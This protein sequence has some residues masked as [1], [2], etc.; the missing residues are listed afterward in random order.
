MMSVGT[1]HSQDSGS[2]NG[3]DARERS[4]SD[5]LSAEALRLLRA[6]PKAVQTGMR[7]HPELTIVAC[8][9]G[10]FALGTVV[11]SRITR[12]LVLAGLS[13][14]ASQLIR[15]AATA[16]IDEFVSPVI[17]RAVKSAAHAVEHVAQG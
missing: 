9:A 6:L 1:E 10:A 16:K 13:A 8:A 17:R 3:A 14:A 12:A 15:N 5:P 2:V 11:G 7:A 4:S